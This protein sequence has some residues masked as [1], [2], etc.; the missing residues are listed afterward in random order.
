MK[1]LSAT[2]VAAVVILRWPVSPAWAQVDYRNLDDDRPT[3]TEDAYPIERYAFELMLPY[4]GERNAGGETVHAVTPELGFGILPNTQVGLKLPLA[5]QSASGSSE[6]GIAGLRVFALYNIATETLHWP[7]VALRID[8]GFP[9]GSLA[10]DGGQVGLEG[11][12]TRSWGRSRIH[13]NGS[14]GLGD[15]ARASASEGIPRWSA[16]LAADYTF[17]RQSLLV[18]ADVDA[19]QATDPESATVVLSAGLRH[20]WTPTLVI[21]LGLARRLTSTGPDFA[22]TIGLSHSFALT[23]LMPRIGPSRG[24]SP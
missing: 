14:Y 5:V 11:I 1:Y 6:A 19:R 8:A 7:G 10:G 15:F 22:L 12:A 21:D 9:V 23:G 2:A 24:N 20:Q 4:Q 17:F 3:A 13:L 18:I 16:G